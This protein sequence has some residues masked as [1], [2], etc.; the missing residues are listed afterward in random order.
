MGG[1]V[2]TAAAPPRPPGREQPVGQKST[3]RPKHTVF[4]ERSCRME[5]T[6]LVLTGCREQHRANLSNRQ[7]LRGQQTRPITLV[8]EEHAAEFYHS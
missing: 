2:W 4:A 5:Q 1:R 3:P 6:V 8:Y 7:A